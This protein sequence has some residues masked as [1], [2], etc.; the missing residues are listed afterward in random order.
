MECGLIP[1]SRRTLTQLRDGALQDIAA[2]DIY[3]TTTNTVISPLL[4][5]FDPLTILAIV[6]AGLAYEE[7]GY[8]DYISLQATPVTATDEAALD[9]G[10]LKGKTL[11]PATAATAIAIFT[12]PAETDIPISTPLTRTDGT[13][14]VTTADAV[15]AAGATTVNIPIEAVNTG[16]SGTIAAGAALTMSNPIQGVAVGVLVVSSTTPGTDIETFDAFKARYLFAFANPPAGGSL[17]DYE[18]WA[19]DIPGI[20][21]AWTSGNGQGP[22]TVVVYIMLDT[23]EAANGGF[24][25]GSNGVA[26]LETRYAP[27]TGDQLTAANAIYPLRPVTALV[28]VFAPVPLTIDFA[29]TGLGANNTEANEAIALSALQALFLA[30][31][32]PLGQTIEPSLWQGALTSALGG[33]PFTLTAPVSPIVVP[34][35]SL[36]QVTAASLTFS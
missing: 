36:P 30:I 2:A 14:Y 22:G 1:F 10:A 28:Y 23:S 3:D 7:Y 9:W 21:R 27:A 24:P 19:L 4:L 20:T 31:G 25:V 35:G 13:A 16:A 5:Q 34:L 26:S 15:I 8:L 6:L 17:T 11:E 32:T 29:F 33:I 12:G 18:Q